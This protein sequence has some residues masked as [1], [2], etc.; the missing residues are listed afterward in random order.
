MFIGSINEDLRAVL[1]E[2]AKDWKQRQVWIG[3]SGNFTVERVLLRAGVTHLHS[4][5]V[6]LYSCALGNYLTGTTMRM[7]VA[8][9]EFAWLGEY[10]D[11]PLRQIAALL[12]CTEMFKF[13][14]RDEIFHRRMEA[15]YRRNFRQLHE[16]TLAKVSKALIDTRLESFFAGDV[17]QHVV[18]APEDCVYIAFPP[19]YTKGYERLY[20]KID[21]VFDW[22][23]PEYDVF[24]DESFRRFTALVQQKT[25]WVTLRDHPV[26]ELDEFLAARIHTGLRSRPVYVY[27]AVGDRKV[28]SPHQKFEPVHVQRLTGEL[29]G[30]LKLMKLTQG[31]LNTLRSEYLNAK[32]VPAAAS[33]R[34]AVLAGDELIGALAFDRST[35]LGGWCEAYMMTDFAVPSHAHPRLSKLV[36]AVSLSHEVKALLE[37]SMNLQVRKI[38]TTA[39]T[40]KPVSQKYRGLY[41]LHSRKEGALNYTARAGRWTMAEALDWWQR[42]YHRIDELETVA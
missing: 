7:D 13:T 22:D 41:D 27:A 15:A 20:R 35:Y 12:L 39:F 29:S 5:D 2:M 38:G 32:I 28:V 1:A 40:D 24:D 23:R 11:T 30:S 17:M 37:M 31:Q 26:E 9:P 6:S 16:R 25:N 14:G 18:N 21:E 33:L 10:V 36:L 42:R 8:S 4:N 19:T 34:F 3:C